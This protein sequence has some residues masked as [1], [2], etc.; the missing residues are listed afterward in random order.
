MKYYN[1]R[2]NES[3]MNEEI[4]FCSNNDV[5]S[6]HYGDIQRVF[7]ATANTD[8]NHE[9]ITNHAVNF[10]GCSVEE[11]I[12]MINP[13]EIVMSAGAWDDIDFINFLYEDTNYFSKYDGI[14]TNDGAV[15]FEVNDN[16]LIETNYLD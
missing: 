5:D 14:V 13:S 7:V 8:T 2:R 12:E 10:Y 3:E 1:Y 16:N 6:R 4:I 9:E 11:A 15:F